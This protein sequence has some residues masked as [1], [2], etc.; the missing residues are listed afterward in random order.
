[1]FIAVLETPKKN[2]TT[3]IFNLIS[4]A[5]FALKVIDN[6]VNNELYLGLESVYGNGTIKDCIWHKISDDCSQDVSIILYTDNKREVV[7]IIIY[8]I[9]CFNSYF[10]F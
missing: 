9:H 4:F 2:I 1:M 5:A 7:S 3:V 8:A 6:Y 10:H